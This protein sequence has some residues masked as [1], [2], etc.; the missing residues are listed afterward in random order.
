MHLKFDGKC[1]IGVFSFQNFNSIN[2]SS[3][4]KTYKYYT[5][6]GADLAVLYCII[7]HMTSCDH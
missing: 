7:D 3:K 6:R 1:C 5:N 2:K 4:F